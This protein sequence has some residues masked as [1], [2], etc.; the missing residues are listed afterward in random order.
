MESFIFFVYYV[1]L[2]RSQLRSILKLNDGVLNGSKDV[3]KERVID[4]EQFGRL[5]T[6]PECSQNKLKVKNKEPGLVVC[7]GTVPEK[8]VNK[9]YKFCTYTE[10]SDVVGRFGPWLGKHYFKTRIEESNEFANEIN[11][12]TR[13]DSHTKKLTWYLFVSLLFCLSTLMI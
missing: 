10:H 11:I 5:A 3:L 9:S 13:F 4:G 1:E 8:C 12:R 2:T 7:S 6:C